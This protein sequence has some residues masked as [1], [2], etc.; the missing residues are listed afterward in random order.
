[1]GLQFP[2]NTP[3]KVQPSFAGI[4]PHY[5]Q[6]AAQLCSAPIDFAWK[7]AKCG[8]HQVPKWGLIIVVSLWQ[9]LIGPSCVKKVVG[10]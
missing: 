10:R 7:A 2:T 1:M 4:V 5:I 8:K 9:N 3:W 6:L